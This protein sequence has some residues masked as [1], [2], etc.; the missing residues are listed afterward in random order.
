MKSKKREKKIFT[1]LKGVESDKF[2]LLNQEDGGKIVIEKGVG[3]IELWS[4]EYYEKVIKKI[5]IPEN[6]KIKI[7][8]R[9]FN[10]LPF[11]KINVKGKEA[12]FIDWTDENRMTVII[13]NETL[14][15]N[16]NEVEK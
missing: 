2:L 16:Q 9:K 3:V 10:F 11:Q 1:I 4:K 13:D 6:F 7:E 12:I 5:V 14:V 8:E 15:I